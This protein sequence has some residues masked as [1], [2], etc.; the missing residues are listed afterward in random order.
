MAIS[1]KNWDL[2][3]SASLGITQRVKSRVSAADW[4][5]RLI[6]GAGS[7]AL[8]YAALAY[9]GVHTWAH[10]PLSL[11]LA[12][13]SLI[14]LA[15][16]VQLAQAGAGA[17]TLLPRPPLW[18]GLT[19]AVIFV[20]LQLTPLPQGLVGLVSP[21]ALEIRALGTGSGLAAYLPL[22]LHPYATSLEFLKLW[23]ALTLFFI[24]LYT[25]QSR[26]QIRWLAEVLLAVAL[27]EALYGLWHFHSHLIWGWKN[28]YTGTRLCGTFINSDHLAGY[29]TMAILL[30]FGLFL[31]QKEAVPALPKDLSGRR[32]LASWSQPEHLEPQCRRYL[33]LF[34]L[35]LLTVALIFTG[36]RGGMISL[37]VGFALMGL[38]ILGQKLKKGHL[39]L[40]AGFLLTAVLYSLWLGSAPLLG[41]F[42]D[43][44]D[45]TRYL[46]FN[47]ALAVF[48]DFPLTGCGLG[49]FGELFYRC[50]PVE[51]GSGWFRH[52]HSE[53]LQVLAETGVFGFTLVAGLWLLFFNSLLRK[54]QSRQ[55]VFARG[56]GLGALAAL[57]AGA[58]H[59]VGEFPFRTP[60][61]TLAYAAIAAIAY[62][63]LHHHQNHPDFEHFSYPALKFPGTPG[64]ALAALLGLAA[65]QA[66][67]MVKAWHFWQAERAAPTEIDSTRA[68]SPLEAK[69]FSR[70]LALNPRNSQYHVG[71]AQVREKNWV[72]DPEALGRAEE[73]Y[74]QAISHSPADWTYRLKLAEF[75][76]RYHRVNPDQNL[77][78]ALQELA[79][80]VT[81]F[82]ESGILH[83]RLGTFLAWLERYQLGLVPPKFISLWVVHLERAVK[84]DPTLRSYLKPPKG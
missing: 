77:S 19:A 13:L 27:F 36:S 28:P 63:I 76:V 31:A 8:I 62:L 42:W 35:L 84:L 82:P 6:L 17:R 53:W 51:L 64:M 57:A 48:R 22:S 56:L 32:W 5:P 68:A 73:L 2:V 24:L 11:W 75:Y 70:A 65:L 67:L 39:Y 37:A 54:W 14:L 29:L 16:G 69:D 74:R 55:D 43:L 40:M 60:A 81:L 66:G 83:W 21:T 10:Y 25:V 47:G 50:Q 52:T 46:A 18:L 58:F 4:G 3:K 7:G 79:A 9:G 45:R 59:A 30:G 1:K 44:H 33:L 34:I 20:F 23:P 12:G 71:L 72:L 15:R 26:R 61:F 80:A 49:A 78:R 41:R 38:L